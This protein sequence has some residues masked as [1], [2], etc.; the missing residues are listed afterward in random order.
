MSRVTLSIAGLV[1]SASLVVLAADSQALKDHNGECV[2]SVPA[3]WS[4]S[5]YGTAQSADKKMSIAV[6]SP[7]HGLTSMAQVR[8]IA[9]TIYKDDKVIK[10]SS[11]EFE[12]EGKSQNGKPNFY[13]AVPGSGKV[14]IAEVIYENDA[15][16]TAK[17]IIESLK[18]AK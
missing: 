12:M 3:D 4:V 15:T 10:D 6:S 13:R 9:P 17:G 7:T 5:S 8:Q 2:A 18:P 11:S 1:L 14:C 16:G